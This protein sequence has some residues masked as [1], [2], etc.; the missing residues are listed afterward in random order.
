LEQG[1]GS[2]YAPMSNA[3]KKPSV[4]DPRCSNINFFL[5]LAQFSIVLSS[6]LHL[7]S[8]DYEVWK[9][10]VGFVGFVEFIE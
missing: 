2:T 6:I 9:E 4:F 1:D 10:F 5:I 8:I 3:S 7:L